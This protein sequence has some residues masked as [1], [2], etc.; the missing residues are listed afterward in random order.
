M[1]QVGRLFFCDDTFEVRAAFIVHD[2]VVDLVAV[3][4]EALHNGVE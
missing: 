1:G 2:L 4:L 3:L